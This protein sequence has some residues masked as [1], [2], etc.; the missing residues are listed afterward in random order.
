MHEGLALARTTPLLVRDIQASLTRPVGVRLRG[1]AAVS[2]QLRLDDGST[3][4]V[5][6]PEA[7][8]HFLSGP[9]LAFEVK[10]VEEASS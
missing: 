9:F 6:A 4:D 3:V 7:F 5:A 8:A 1:G 2:I 10:R